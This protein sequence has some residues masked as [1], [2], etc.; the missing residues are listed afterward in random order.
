M[1]AVL[2]GITDRHEPAYLYKTYET[3][4]FVIKNFKLKGNNSKLKS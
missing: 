1:W 2:I 4:E 3:S